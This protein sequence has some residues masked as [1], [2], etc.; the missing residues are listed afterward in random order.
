LPVQATFR[1]KTSPEPVPKEQHLESAARVTRRSTVF[2]PSPRPPAAGHR[3]PITSLLRRCSAVSVAATRKPPFAA[4]SR[5]QTSPLTDSN[6]R[7]PPYHR[8]TRR[9]AR[10]SAGHVDQRNPGSRRNPLRT[11][12]RA[13]TCV[14][15][16]VFP[17]C[18]LGFLRL[19][20]SSEMRWRREAAA[21]AIV[22][23]EACEARRL[24]PAR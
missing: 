6:R 24:R 12:D 17:Q 15:G 18:S 20:P 22:S 10:A 13:W 3:W 4:T 14:P 19:E 8:A 9:Q 1:A 5:F 7:P 2:K 23:R 16:L 21:L 11:S